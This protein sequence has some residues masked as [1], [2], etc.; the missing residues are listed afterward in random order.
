MPN[1]SQYANLGAGYKGT[2]VDQLL[3][4]IGA[5]TTDSNRAALRLWAASEGTATS[6]NPLAISGSNAGATQCIAQCGTNSPVYAYS[7]MN[8]GVA[9]T[10]KFLQGS[11]YTVVRSAFQNDAGLGAIWASINTSPW[12]SGCEGGF[13]PVALA[14]PA[15][16]KNAP[17]AGTASVLAA[18]S[19][20]STG[21]QATGGSTIFGRPATDCAL[22]LPFGT[23][24]LNYG[25][26]QAIL[27]GLVVVGGVVVL[28]VGVGIMV[29]FGLPRSSP[30]QK[31]APTK[32][33]GKAVRASGQRRTA[34]RAEATRQQRQAAKT[35]EAF[36]LAEA[37]EAGRQSGVAKRRT[38]G[39]DEPFSAQP[40][41]PPIKTPA[42]QRRDRAA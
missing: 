9:A 18:G 34:R 26:V 27:G 42:E 25:Q 30:L 11:Y 3:Q 22:P 6:N 37:K 2:W 23:C 33:A 35:T 38:G 20:K 16:V 7:S 39:A 1:G 10:A 28:A 29:A 8:A 36:D 14:G 17:S 15:G 12:C 13:Y 5:P 31:V 41:R 24:L 19:D 40:E 32:L 4:A 21:G